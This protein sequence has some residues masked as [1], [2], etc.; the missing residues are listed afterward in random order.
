MTWYGRA[1]TIHVLWTVPAIVLLMLSLTAVGLVTAAVQVQRR[2][3]GLAMPVVLQAWMFASPVL[4]SL[5][6]ARQTLP[7]SLYAVYA[8][9][10]MASVVDTFRRAT[11]LA[12]APDVQALATGTAAMLALLPVAYMYFKLREMTM[13]DVV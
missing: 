12:E 5:D 2:D 3:V 13:A 10:P 1:I 11:V 6:A 8:A 4:Y 9:N 7:P